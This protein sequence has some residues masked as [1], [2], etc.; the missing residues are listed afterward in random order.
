MAWKRV[1]TRY[2]GR[3]LSWGSIGLLWCIALTLGYIG[4]IKLGQG[5]AAAYTPTDSLYLALQLFAL[6][7][8]FAPGP[9]PW[10]LEVARFLAP[11]VA[12]YTLLLGIAYLFVEQVQSLRLAYLRNHVVICGLG[13]KGVLLAA[14]FRGRGLAVVVIDQDRDNP[15]LS[16]CRELN[17]FVLIGDA[18]SP[19]ILRR[20]G[21]A[22]AQI[23]LAVSGDDPVNAEIAIHARNLAARRTG[24]PLNCLVHVVDS[25]LRELLRERELAIEEGAAF[26]LEFFSSY[27]LG[28]LAMLD[29]YPP[30]GP[31]QRQPVLLVIGLGNMG[32]SLVVRAARMWR[33][34][35]ATSGEQ[36]RI[37]VVDRDAQS[38]V[39][40][41]KLRY[42]RLTTVCDL[43][44]LQMDIR[45][46]EFQRADFLFDADGQPAVSSVYICLD[47]DSLGLSA[48]LLLR[49]HLRGHSIPIVVR[50]ASETGL[51][52]L[53]QQEGDADS[54]F[55]D[56]RVF[57]L[58]ERTCEPDLLLGGAHE[59]LA[60]AFHEHQ[61]D[62][63]AA[64][65]DSPAGDLSML[66]WD[67]L[68]DQVKESNR[69][70]ARQIGVALRAVGCSLAPLTDWDADSFE[71]AP[72]AV[73]SIARLQ[74]D[75]TH[76]QSSS[77]RR[78]SADRTRASR[79]KQRSA[80]VA[81][82]DLS[83]TEREK[84]RMAMRALPRFLAQAG[85]Q[86]VRVK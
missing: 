51:A 77:A 17:I 69:Q 84:E 6:N 75:Q 74:H 15:L 30:F 67:E 47:D 49:Q 13:R 53:L 63:H 61:T 50:T 85:L 66:R 1:F 2:W 3:I 36:L 22:R 8:S 9:K 44:S 16:A 11:V 33:S 12:A 45:R 58:L 62:T 31:A 55:A 29:E 56:L 27:H 68:P 78:A 42:P 41:L 4:I 19:E 72:E 23:L 26:Q 21:V 65:A 38:K 37:F 81:W 24:S 73:E 64:A 76:R 32:R 86:I 40:T 25:H 28:A 18:A 43:T 57:P 14:A 5:A 46:A 59:I 10:E 52:T 54:A 82:E 35:M 20:A 48:A 71:F 70:A 7:T 34:S 60:R 80:A 79:R 39:E 83:E